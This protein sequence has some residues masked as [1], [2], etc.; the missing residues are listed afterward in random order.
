M[1]YLLFALGMPGTGELLVVLLIVLVLFGGSKIPEVA[2]TLGNGLR[3]LKKGV[4]AW[5]YLD[6]DTSNEESDKEK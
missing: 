3:E 5:R 6:D 4:N 1:R 2:R